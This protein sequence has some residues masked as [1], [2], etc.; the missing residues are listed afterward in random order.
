M[1]SSIEKQS[2]VNV[3]KI[4]PVILTLMIFSLV[5]DNS[6]KIISP[7]LVKYFGVSASTVSWQ[8]TLAGLVIGIGAVVYSSLS[9]SISVRNLLAAGIILIC[10]GS[11]L[12]YI[13]HTNYWL[14]VFSRI[15]QAAG[16]GAT[17]TLY[18]IFIA[19]YASAED[20]K[21]YMGFSTSSYQL[22]TVIGILAG[23][24][25]STYLQW[26]NLFLIP[27]LSIVLLPF[28][29]K[30]LPKEER[31][32][33]NV[34]FIGLI[35]IATVSTSIMLYMS[36][37]NWGIFVLF[38]ASVIAFLV[39]ISKKKNAFITI[40]FF[41]NKQFLFVLVVAFII[42][43]T[44]A[45]YALNTLSFLLTTLYDIKLDTVSLMFI[46]ACLLAAFV[47]ALSGKIG[48]YLSSKQ[49]VYLAISLIIIS[50]LMGAF[51]VD[52][53]IT[54]FVISLILF[55][56]S[57]ALLYAPLIDTSI[58]NVP[59]EK[60]G[61]ALGFYNLCINIAMSAGF[62]YSAFLIDKKDLQFSFLRFVTKDATALNYS[63]IIMI[64]AAIAVLAIVLFWALVGRKL[65]NNN[66]RKNAA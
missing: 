61:T 5:I 51:F 34:D 7:D 15:I 52:T 59:T 36:Y 39:Y 4:V 65:E 38:V 3:S 10:I 50:I 27:L 54:V 30:Y 33:N 14:V 43:S 49:G 35:L 11:L 37:F 20:Q 19:K 6:F 24:F 62:T 47:G 25:V 44:Y 57:F 17:E 16:L 13:T 58:K 55:S 18:L 12:G 42:Y 66:Q 31:K 23:G 1:N 22:A 29:L 60:S 32:K 63:S 45:A 28:I 48:K 64:I 53:S 26:Q 2:I 56:C 41:K 40:E 46:P 21:K 9:D 8:V